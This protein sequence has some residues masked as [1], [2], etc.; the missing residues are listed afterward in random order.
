VEQHVY[1][2]VGHALRADHR[3]SSNAE[4]ARNGW[5]KCLAWFQQDLKA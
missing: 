1:P 3:P 5:A 2:G 4:A